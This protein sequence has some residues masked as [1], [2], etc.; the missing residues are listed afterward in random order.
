MSV[1]PLPNLAE[2]NVL[3]RQ[4][5]QAVA[6]GDVLLIDGPLG[7]GKTTFVRALVEHLGGV[8]TRVASPTFTLL[9]QYQGQ[10]V[11]VIHIDAYRLQGPADLD[12]LG[13]SDLAENHLAVIEWGERVAGAFIHHAGCWRLIFAHGE[14][15]DTRVVT[16]TAPARCAQTWEPT[17]TLAAAQAMTLD[18]PVTPSADPSTEPSTEPAH[19]QSARGQVV[20]IP[21][22]AQGNDPLAKAYVSAHQ[23]T[24]AFRTLSWVWFTAALAAVTGCGLLA[25]ELHGQGDALS[26]FGDWPAFLAGAVTAA[27]LVAL[28]GAIRQQRDPMALPVVQEAGMAATLISLVYFVL[29]DPLIGL[30]LVTAL[31]CTVYLATIAFRLLALVLGGRRGAHAAD[32]QT[33]PGGWPL[34]TVLVP[35]YREVHV[36]RNILAS[37]ARLDYPREQLDVKFLLEADDP[38]TLAALQAAGIPEW[39]EVVIVP[40][41]QPKT[42]PRACNH[43][44]QRA[45]GD[46]LV[47]FD[48]EDRPEPDQLKQAVLAFSV[49]PPQVACL[50]AQLAYHNHR[51][52]LLT[53]WFAMEYNVWFRRYL[54]GLA[55]LGSPLPL[56]GTSNH[57]RTAV[58]RTLGGWDPFNVTEDCDLGVRLH[59]ANHRTALLDSTTWEEANSRVGNWLRQRS[60]WLKGYFVTHVVWGRRPLWLLFKLGPWSAWGFLLS[61]LFVPLLAATNLVLWSYAGLYATLV[62][63][64]L[65]H[66]FSLWTILAERDWADERLSW[67]MWYAGPLE[68]PFFGGLSQIFFI[69][70]AVLLAG[71]A[72]FMVI[73]GLAG[74]R[75]GQR[76]VWLVSLLLPLYWVLISLAAW[77]GLWQALVK[78]H[79]WEKT[80]HGLD[81]GSE[82]A[83][84]RGSERTATS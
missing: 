21:A 45:R 80:L 33:P 36:A 73:A 74:R 57:F 66:G 39:A 19:G 62:G 16:V 15:P 37:L 12:G 22:D 69:A 77:K 27:A 42:K 4:I 5:A 11:G 34:Y 65:A 75:P 60:R 47:V 10:Q 52:N 8:P 24:C 28:A 67:P 55:R 51:Q 44:L 78:P 76:G 56:G 41:A 40:H 26:R 68:D 84:E 7:A 50:Q 23:L 38:A 63:I 43:G 49:A 61:V 30:G 64:D 48:A 1:R 25:A 35:L 20:T 9:N 82:G 2:T 59:L 31:L 29:Y 70:S 13:F 17:A 46:F 83:K 53:R 81:T 79:Y 71:N 3:A 18:L 14:E 6:T 54:P 32:L 58:L 72:A